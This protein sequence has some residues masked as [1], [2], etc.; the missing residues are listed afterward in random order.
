MFNESDQTNF[1]P[2]CKRDLSNTKWKST[3]HGAT[4]YKSADCTCGRCLTLR[5]DFHGSGH[6]SWDG[7]DNWKD[8]VENLGKDIKIK[9]LEDEVKIVEV[10]KLPS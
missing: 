2:Y 8:V 7:K 4:H 1:C 3:W 10:K 5:A 6:D 9:D